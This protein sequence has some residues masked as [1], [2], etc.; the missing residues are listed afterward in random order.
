MTSSKVSVVVPVFNGEQFI[1]EAL[2][3]LRRE[4]EIEAEI[5][6]VDDGSTDGSASAVRALSQQ[7]PRIR[8][9]TGEHRGVSATRNIGV[10]A[11]TGDYITFL[12]CDDLCPPGRIARQLRK[13]VSHPGVLVVIGETLWFETLTPEFN[14]AP[15]TRQARTLCVTLHS[16]LFDRSVFATYGSFDE[17]LELCEDLDFFIRLSEAGARFLVETEVASLYRRHADNMTKDFQRL[18]MATV[19]ALQRSIARR[20]AAGHNQPLD[21]F[22]LRR[23]TME[24]IFSSAGSKSVLD[25]AAAF[26]LLA[27]DD[28]VRQ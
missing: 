2:G 14:P 21:P 7:D 8:L 10:H 15:G 6:V 18:R 27:N 5:I 12:D 9:I 26:D 17:T 11:A 1:G 16:A 25:R 3:S 28:E 20:R 22:F 13:L 4:Q 24:T 19:A 23:F